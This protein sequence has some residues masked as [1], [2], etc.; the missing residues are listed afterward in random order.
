MRLRRA[1][2]SLACVG[3]AAA[4]SQRG[5]TFNFDADR[6][7][8]PP[9]RFALAAMRQ[10]GPGSWLVRRDGVNGALVHA[11][12]PAAA[13]F[14]LALA[15]D[16]SERDIVLTVRLRLGGGSMAGG[17]VW[18]YI[19]AGNFYAAILDLARRELVLWRVTSGNRVILESK[20]DLELDTAAWHALKVVHDDEDIAVSLGGIRVFDDRDRRADRRAPTGRT[21]VIAAGNAEVWF[22]DLRIDPPRNR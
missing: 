3:A 10:D 2:V 8:E 14:A 22:D 17:L 6:A 15:T 4:S 5:Q 1:L 18:R 21:G 12:N 20:D 7:G 16:G 13:G 11:A 19:D 9:A